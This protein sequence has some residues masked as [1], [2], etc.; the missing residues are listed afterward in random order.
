MQNVKGGRD[1]KKKSTLCSFCSSVKHLSR[2]SADE[3]MWMPPQS[4]SLMQQIFIHI[5]CK[6]SKK[7]DASIM[8]SLNLIA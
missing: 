2:G 4:I 6:S 5:V 3:L 1:T 8:E 7:N